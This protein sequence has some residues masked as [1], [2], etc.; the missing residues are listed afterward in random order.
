M[1]EREVSPE[2]FR[3]CWGGGGTASEVK[4]KKG[5]KGMGCKLEEIP[6]P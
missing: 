2:R 3:V 4:G 6:N 5:G 1:N